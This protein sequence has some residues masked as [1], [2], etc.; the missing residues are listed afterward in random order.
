LK[1]KNGAF[2]ANLS[3]LKQKQ[4]YDTKDTPTRAK[5]KRKKTNMTNEIIF[6]KTRLKI[7]ISYIGDLLLIPLLYIYYK[8]AFTLV[9]YLIF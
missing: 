5:L 6:L 1:Q 8:F 2:E 3:N 7:K 4:K 9:G